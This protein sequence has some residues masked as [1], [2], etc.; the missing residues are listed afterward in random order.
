MNSLTNEN[1]R[2]GFIGIGNMGSRIAT[3]LLQ[4]GYRLM[5]YSRRREAA[6]A[7][8]KYGATVAETIAVVAAE[9]DVIF[10]SLT[11]DDAVKSVYSGP[12]GVFARA[13]PGTSIIEM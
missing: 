8:V 1:T 13:R 3:R 9:S 11:D 5:A 7:M 10:S 6:D 4:H 2:L 12:Q